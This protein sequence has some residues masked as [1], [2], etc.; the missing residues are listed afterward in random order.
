MKRSWY[1]RIL[2]HSSVMVCMPWRSDSCVRYCRKTLHSSAD[3]RRRVSPMPSGSRRN[4]WGLRSSSSSGKKTR[5]K[6]MVRSTSVFWS[7]SGARSV[8]CRLV[9]AFWRSSRAGLRQSCAYAE[10][11]GIHA[12]SHAASAESE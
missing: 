12:A 11:S 5:S 3:A 6:M 4:T 8:R 10:R 9:M 7:I 1:P 2:S